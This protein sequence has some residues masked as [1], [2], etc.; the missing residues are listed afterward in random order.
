MPLQSVYLERDDNDESPPSKVMKLSYSEG[1]F[2]RGQPQ[3][4]ENWTPPVVWFAIGDYEEG[5]YE[6]NFRTDEPRTFS[7]TK[8]DLMRALIGLGAL[9]G[10]TNAA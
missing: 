4:E 8:E 3:T 2:M 5:T 1:F 7:V 10:V 6:D 9:D